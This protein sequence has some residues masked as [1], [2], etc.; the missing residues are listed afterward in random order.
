VEQGLAWENDLYS[1]CMTTA[2]SREGIAAFLG[3]REP[4]FRG[5]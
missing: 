3:K 1:Y 2:D 4:Q 5:E